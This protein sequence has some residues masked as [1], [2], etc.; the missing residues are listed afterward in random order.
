MKD[1]SFNMGVKNAEQLME[2]DG[3]FDKMLLFRQAEVVRILTA[4]NGPND[5]MLIE[6][7]AESL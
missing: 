4:S 6:H 2:M 5:E 7:D 1:N 3:G